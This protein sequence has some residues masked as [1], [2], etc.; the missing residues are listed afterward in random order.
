MGNIFGILGIG[1][2]LY[3]IYAFYIMKTKGI[4]NQNITLPKGVDE[5]SCKDIKAY[6]KKISLPLLL[7]G[8]VLVFYGALEL[9]NAYFMEVG[10]ALSFAIAV[11]LAVLLWFAAV[12]RKCNKEYFGV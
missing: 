10:I 4:L 3:C 8:I 5:K 7:L 2:G 6:I 11:V 1:A 12:T 9:I